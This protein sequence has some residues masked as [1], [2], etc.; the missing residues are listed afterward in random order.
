[1]ARGFGRN[2]GQ[3]NV[4]ENVASN[5]GT[6]FSLKP[7]AKY[8]TGARTIIKI[9]GNLVGFAFS[10]SWQIST[11]A[12]EI[13]TIDDPIAYELAPRQISVTG[14]VG[15]FIIPGKSPQAEL[16]QTDLANFLMNKYITIEVRDSATDTI[17]F[18]TNRAM[19][20]SSNGSTSAE[21]PAEM[22]LS[23][24][25]VGWQAETAPTPPADSDM[26]NVSDGAGGILNSIKSKFNF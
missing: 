16:L 17:I 5:A 7:T 3:I 1:M 23:W 18:K 25:A 4:V 6:I 19:V 21:K 9:N 24:K 15:G 11:D 12:T 13:R 2:E 14:T 26:D 10:V 20:T 22:N 8:L